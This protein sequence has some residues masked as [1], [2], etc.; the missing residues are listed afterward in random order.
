MIYDKSYF[1]VPAMNITN[2]ITICDTLH[3]LLPFL[4]FK[5]RKKTY[6][7]EHYFQ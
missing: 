7:D 6:M 2:N 5:K 4:Q 3:G 1:I